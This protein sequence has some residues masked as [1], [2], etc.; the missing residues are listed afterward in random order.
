[1]GIYIIWRI[2]CKKVYKNKH[3]LLEVAVIR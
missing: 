1:M 2:K 3:M